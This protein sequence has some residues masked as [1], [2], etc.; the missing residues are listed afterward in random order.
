MGLPGISYNPETPPSFELD[1]NRYAMLKLL[2]TLVSSDDFS[3]TM[4]VD[5]QHIMLMLFLQVLN[6]TAPHPYFLP[7]DWCTPTMASNFTQL[8]FQDQAWTLS[9]N[10]MT[11]QFVYQFLQLGEPIAN[12]IVSCFVSGHLLDYV[13][14]LRGDEILWKWE[15]GGIL[16]VFVSGVRR[17]DAAVTY[18]FELD[19]IF[20]VCAMFIIWQDIPHLHLL[21][22]CCPDHPVWTECLQK[23]D[24]IPEHFELS[25]S[26]YDREEILSTVSAFRLLFEGGGPLMLHSRPTVSSLWRRLWQRHRNIGKELTGASKV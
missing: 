5:N 25:L 22:Q 8:A 18:L 20:A 21:A 11:L 2:Y 23:L 24:T 1:S 7:S 4:M 3:T 26:L 12:Q 13:V 19:N 17:S 10:Y 9:S 6:S 14:K 16:G 15:L